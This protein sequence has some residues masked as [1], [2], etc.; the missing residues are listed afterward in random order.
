MSL[1]N[2]SKWLQKDVAQMLRTRSEL[3]WNQDYFEK[4][5]LPLLNV[6]E[7]GL[8]VDVGCGFGG[9]TFLLARFRPDVT[10]IGVDILLSPQV[11]NHHR[12]ES[13]HS[14]ASFIVADAN[15]LPFP[16]ASV[17]CIVSQTLFIHLADVI[18]P[19]RE[20]RRV[21][22]PNGKVM[23]AE[24]GRTGAWDTFHSTN[25]RYNDDDWQQE[26]FRLNRISMRGR[27]NV[28]KGDIRNG[29]LLPN[30]L[31]RAGFQVFDMRLND[32]VPYLY[33]PYQSEQQTQEREQ[34]LR[35][36]DLDKTVSAYSENIKAGGGTMND[37]SSLI[38]N[39]STAINT[40]DIAEQI[41]QNQYVYVDLSPICLIFATP[42]Q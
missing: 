11:E 17:D 33:P 5:I 28:G 37:I 20:I 30:Y 12:A 35:G 19:L 6:P 2:E 41:A 10:L 1:E 7:N 42:F 8:V 9:L 3:F 22:Q 36:T 21:L 24:Y 34:H 40:D 18:R 14:N 31:L 27:S 26:M 32:R 13:I 23:F 16:T 4:I 38:F 29:I 25:T 15:H 39:L